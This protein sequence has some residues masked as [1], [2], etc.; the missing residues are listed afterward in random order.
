MKNENENPVIT[1]YLF[2]YQEKSTFRH[3]R[4]TACVCDFKTRM[5]R[6]E[7]NWSG[8]SRYRIAY[9]DFPDTR[10]NFLAVARR[11]DEIQQAF[12]VMKPVR[13]SWSLYG[14]YERWINPIINHWEIYNV[15]GGIKQADDI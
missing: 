7:T 13:F 2:I 11:I 14:D 5:G 4:L 8:Y 6:R 15:D 12:S 10:Y 1:D 9:C 3:T